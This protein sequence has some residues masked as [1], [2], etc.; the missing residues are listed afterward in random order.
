[1]NIIR[2]SSPR[3]R[4]LGL[5]SKYQHSNIQYSVPGIGMGTVIVVVDEVDLDVEPVLMEWPALQ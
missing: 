2:P 4:Y 1:M 3:R 5:I